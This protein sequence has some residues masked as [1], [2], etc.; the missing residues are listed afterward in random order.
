M[1][2]YL[3]LTVMTLA[4]LPGFTFAQAARDP[5]PLQFTNQAE[6]DR[7][8]ALTAELRCVKCQNQSLADSGAGIAQDMR[9]E[10]LALMRQGKTDA[11]VKHYLVARYGEFVLYR[12]QVDPKTWLLWFGPVLVLLVGGLVVVNIVR[13][14]SASQ[15]DRAGHRRR[16]DTSPDQN[17]PDED[18]E[19]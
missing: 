6:A 3:W 9:H 19:W 17:T 4:L 16:E 10:V 15:P 2:R 5:A 12:P 18:Q 11:E 13:K 7:F 14:R 1:R 8:H